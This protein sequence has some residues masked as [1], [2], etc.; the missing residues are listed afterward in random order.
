M[1]DVPRIIM[2]SRSL[3]GLKAIMLKDKRN[4]TRKINNRIKFNEVIF[5]RASI[6]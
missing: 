2:K 1:I 4:T 6:T 3:K 5:K